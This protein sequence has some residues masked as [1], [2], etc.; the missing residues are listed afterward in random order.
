MQRY[1]DRESAITA[2]VIAHGKAEGIENL[3]S[4]AY[5]CQHCKLYFLASPISTTAPYICIY[6]LPTPARI[7]FE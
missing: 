6:C 4:A 1:A 7:W 3:K 2:A 5:Q